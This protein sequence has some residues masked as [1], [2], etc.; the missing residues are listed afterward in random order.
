MFCP[1]CHAV[2][3]PRELEMDI[4]YKD[5]TNEY[6]LPLYQKLIDESNKINPEK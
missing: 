5:L 3:E 2:N 6:L 4:T 1:S